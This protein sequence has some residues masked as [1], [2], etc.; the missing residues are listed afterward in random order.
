MQ[1]A[2][3]S[4]SEVVYTVLFFL[5]INTKFNGNNTISLFIQ[6][7]IFDI[8][9]DLFFVFPNLTLPIRFLKF[10]LHLL[11]VLL[12]APYFLAGYS[13]SRRFMLTITVGDVCAH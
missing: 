6:F 8:L 10:L 1:F 13:K 11:K 7:K 5:N 3:Y 12:D 2:R 4:T 9:I